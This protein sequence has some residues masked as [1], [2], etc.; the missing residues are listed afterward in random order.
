MTTASST[1]GRI[2]TGPIPLETLRFG[3]PIAIGMGLQTAFNL[4]DAYIVSRLTP[5]VAGPALGAIGICDQLSAIGTIMSYGLT[6]ASTALIA[7]AHGRGDRDEVRRLVWQ[8][9]LAVGALS[10]IFGLGAILFAEPIVAGAVGAK[11]KV[12][13]LGAAYLRVNSGGSF[14]IF[15]LFQLT[16]IQRA[17]GSAKTPVALLVLSNVLNL[18]LAIIFVYGPGPAPPIFSFGPVIASALHIPRLELV[19]AAWATILA[20][21]VTLVPVVILLVKRFDVIDR[22]TVRG[23]DWALLRSL[24]RLGW[25]SSTQLVVRML[26]MLLTHS[27]VARA[28]TTAEDQTATTALGIVFRLETLAFFMAMGWGSAAQTFVGQNLGAARKDRARQ[29][30]VYAAIYN[31]ALMVLIAAAYQAAGRPIV[32]FFDKDPRVVS[33]STTYIAYVVWSYVGLGTGVVLGSA[34]TGAGAT[35]TTLVTDLAVVVGFQVPASL[36]AVLLPGA[37]LE[38]LWVSITATYIVS[39]IAYLLVFR[40]VGWMEA[41]S[42]IAGKRPAPATPPP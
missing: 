39:G 26:A 16:G 17:L 32:E 28:F 36:L 29:S 5:D 42:G 37:T 34:I 1:S 8:S 6:T 10:L 22:S 33:I 24:F 30:G 11:G 9:I 14:S 3:L 25:P 38:R 40:L 13:E 2:L 15:F 27:L 23:P 19:G 31:A 18:F 4:V 35:R 21:T 12:A 7:Q 41:A 20:R